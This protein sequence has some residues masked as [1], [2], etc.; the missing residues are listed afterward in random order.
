M[1][2]FMKAYF[3]TLCQCYMVRLKNTGGSPEQTPPIL[4]MEGVRLK[5]HGGI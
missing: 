2:F 4:K 5:I 3:K 1:N